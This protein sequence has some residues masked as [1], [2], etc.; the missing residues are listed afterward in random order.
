MIENKKHA[1][2]LIFFVGVCFLLLVWLLLRRWLLLRLP[3]VCFAG[4]SSSSL[5]SSSSAFFSASYCM[6]SM[7]GQWIH[8]HNIYTPC[9]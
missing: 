3:S 8:R 7:G 2:L 5:A 6:R 1:Y 9:L 4:F